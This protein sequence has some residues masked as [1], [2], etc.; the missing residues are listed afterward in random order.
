MTS[1]RSL[2]VSLSVSGPGRRTGTRTR[3]AWLVGLA[4]I[5]MLA[6]IPLALLVAPTAANFQAPLTQ[7]IFY[8]HVPAA[9]A[10]YLAFGATA[11]ASAFV[12]FRKDLR[13]D[14]VAVASAEVGTLFGA[15]ALLTGLVWAQ[16]EFLGYN[17]VTDPK[18]IT[19]AVLLA[20]YLA[21]FALRSNVDEPDKR[22]RLSAVFGLLCVLGVPLSYF[23]SNASVHPDFTR[24]ESSLD[25]ALGWILLAS[26]LVFTI[27]YAA[28]VAIRVRI[29]ALEAEP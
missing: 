5:A 20:A 24:P 25:P 14:R 16:Q 2:S 18:V 1:P 8:D 9:W 11:I 13:W 26:T 29:L 22:A 23:A 10:A 15:I 28:L 27:L 7:R 19:L 12:L 3:G 4:V 21:Y 17:P 6:Q